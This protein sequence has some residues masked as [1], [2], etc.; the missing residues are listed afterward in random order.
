MGCYLNGFK[1]RLQHRVNSITCKKKTHLIE[2]NKLDSD[3]FLKS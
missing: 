2:H 1:N 3:L